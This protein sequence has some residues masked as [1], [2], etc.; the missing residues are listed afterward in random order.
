M[1]LETV[2]MVPANNSANYSCKV[3]TRQ[4]RPFL[5]LPLVMLSGITDSKYRKVKLLLSPV[6]NFSSVI[7]MNIEACTLVLMLS[8]H[9]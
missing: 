3:L 7:Q 9:L 4:D 5:R 2:C 8:D 6:V 1:K